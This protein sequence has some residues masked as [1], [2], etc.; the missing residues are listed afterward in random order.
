MEANMAQGR[1]RTGGPLE[2]RIPKHIINDHDWIHQHKD[3]LIQQYGECYMIVHHQQVLSTGK[4]R[5]EALENAEHNLPDDIEEITAMVEWVG[6]R[7]RAYLP[8]A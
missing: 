3:E 2:E 1:I 6:Y 5:K 7:Y 4:S 8:Q